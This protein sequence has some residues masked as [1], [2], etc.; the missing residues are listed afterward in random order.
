M[1]PLLEQ[2]D[3]WCPG[4]VN[5]IVLTVNLPE[6]GI[7]TEGI[8]LPVVRIDNS[9]PLGFGANHNQAFRHCRT[10]WF[11]VLNPD[12][13]LDVDA[14]SALLALAADDTGLLAP[15]VHEPG[16]AEAEPYRT[17]PTPA[18]LLRRRLPGH[19]P[20][21][22]PDWV[23]G[24]FMLLRRDAFEAVQGFDERYYMYCEDVD[25]CARLRLAGWQ[26]R[27]IPSV[28]VRHEAQR[29]SQ[30]SLRPLV[31]HVASL[32]RLWSSLAFW[33]YAALLRRVE[34]R[35]AAL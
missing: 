23:A 19:R 33:R 24:M 26:V 31:W 29:A 5:R 32:A 6:P 8:G 28:V 27:S 14:V 35:N 11:L 21:A 15:R 20:P 7:S 17:L 30:S 25:L 22:A 2:L 3:R 9:Q 4:V 34:N 13:R 12:I 1:R 16:K 10:P 18:E